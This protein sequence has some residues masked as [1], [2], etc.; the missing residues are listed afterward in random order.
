MANILATIGSWYRE[1]PQ[2]VK[3]PGW[4]KDASDKE[5]TERRPLLL[6]R[7]QWAQEQGTNRPVFS[8]QV[9]GLVANDVPKYT[10]EKKLFGFS[11][12]KNEF[13]QQEDEDAKIVQRTL[14]NSR[15]KRITELQITYEQKKDE[16]E[17]VLTLTYGPQGGPQALK[18]VLEQLT[19]LE[20]QNPP[21]IDLEQIQ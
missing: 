14:R 5:L 2:Y 21:A 20:T 7:Y 17:C 1:F 4:R 10:L 15:L 11:D 18:S 19:Q 3:H 6:V 9:Q 16:I 8:A 12:P 13:D